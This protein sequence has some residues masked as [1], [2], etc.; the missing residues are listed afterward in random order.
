MSNLVLEAIHVLYHED[1][2]WRRLAEFVLMWIVVFCVYLFLH[3]G[4]GSTSSQNMQASASYTPVVPP[5]AFSGGGASGS[6]GSGTTISMPMNAKDMES[7]NRLKVLHVSAQS[8]DKTL[9]EVQRCEKMTDIMAPIT[10]YD[11]ARAKPVHK[12][13]I[14]DGD[15]CVKKVQS[16]DARLKRLE[17][18]AS[19][20]ESSKNSAAMISAANA[21]ADL[22]SFDEGRSNFS[23]HKR[24]QSTAKKAFEAKQHSD[25]RIDALSSANSAYFEN[26]SLAA[27]G[28]IS[29]LYRGLSPLD[30]DRT[31]AKSSMAVQNAKNI[32]EGAK[33]RASE[34]RQ[35]EQ[36]L[37]QLKAKY[38]RSTV[39]KAGRLLTELETTPKTLFTEKDSAKIESLKGTIFDVLKKELQKLYL[40]DAKETQ[41]KT[42]EAFTEAY[43]QFVQL[44]PARLGEINADIQQAGANAADEFKESDQRLATLVRS[45]ASV[46]NNS[47][48][49]N[50]DAL[51]QA[52]TQLTEFDLGRVREEQKAALKL[53]ED[54]K[55][56]IILSDNRINAFVRAYNDFRVNGCSKK[57][58]STLRNN[59]NLLQNFDKERMIPEVKAAYLDAQ[60]HLVRTYCLEDKQLMRV[61]N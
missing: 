12:A 10:D 4:G 52:Q 34:M 25:Q 28:E 55:D 57:R 9:P 7:D 36:Y 47:S 35:V 56:G 31:D 3:G 38:S 22:N 18:S 8:V 46:R 43:T 30:K 17:E 40:A 50:V 16:S 19:V 54:A 59:N 27:E 39:D 44:Y 1:K 13:I 24:A 42:K 41:V 26:Y 58:L 2:L 11:R 49:K 61:S 33:V 5:G 23:I 45:A 60:R 48:K 6:S 53:C 32:I 37:T 51:L 20:Y 15:Q 29:K 14:V 21:Y